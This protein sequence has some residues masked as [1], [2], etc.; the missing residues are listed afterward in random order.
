MRKI[1][2][3]PVVPETLQSAPRPTSSHAVEPRY[4][5]APDVRQQL[6]ADQ[7]SKCAYCEAIIAKEYNDVEHF[8][9]KSIYYWL[10]HDWSNLLY[11]CNVCNRTF[12]KNQFPLKGAPNY[13]KIALEKPLIINPAEVDP[14]D[15]I[16]FNRHIAVPKM[17][18][19]KEDEVGR[20]TI[21]L[22]QLNNRE[23]RPALVNQRE[24]LFDQYTR[25]RNAIRIAQQMLMN[26]SAKKDEC[27]KLIAA[28]TDMIDSMI[29]P[30]HAFSGMLI[31]QTGV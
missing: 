2:K 5:K 14:L 23:K 12:K 3:S 29:S 10:G 6:I 28:C 13:K 25:A 16:A 20:T 11:S 17:V 22:F 27:L 1:C 8:R 9:P 15:H 30:S 7:H 24:Q 31:G 18:D 21:D 19:G 26:G 4:Y